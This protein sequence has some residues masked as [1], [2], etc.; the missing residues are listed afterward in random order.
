MRALL[1][2]LLGSV[3]AADG[4]ASDQRPNALLKMAQSRARFTAGRV[5]L[6]EEEWYQYNGREMRAFQHA[7]SIFGV[8]G[9]IYVL[10]GDDQGVLVRDSEGKPPPAGGEWTNPVHFLLQGGRL[11]QHE[12]QL[13]YGELF[14]PNSPN[15]RVPD[16][17]TYGI[18][19]GMMYGNLEECLYGKRPVP[20]T[21]RESREGA[22]WIVQ[23]N[24]PERVRTWWIDPQRGWNPVRVRVELTSGGWREARMVLKQFG[25]TWFP[26]KIDHFSSDWKDGAVPKRTIRVYEAE[27]NAPGQPTELTPADIGITEGMSIWLKDTF[28]QKSELGRYQ[29]GQFVPTTRYYLEQLQRGAGDIQVI[30]PEANQSIGQLRRL[31]VLLSDWERYVY[32]FIQRYTLDDAQRERALSV[33][34][35][36][37]TLARKYLARRDEEL[38]E[39]A[40]DLEGLTVAARDVTVKDGKRIEVAPD[41]QR[42][43]RAQ[44][45][46][47]RLRDFMKPLDEIFENRLKP[48]LEKLPT[49]KQREAAAKD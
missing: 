13:S 1:C 40:A 20:C 37:Q 28:L 11:W 34:H 15:T 19:A 8:S 38:A 10:R 3:L 29:N 30:A 47:E 9:R 32:E 39:I 35:E 24:E 7:T 23:A 4:T 46:D 16:V 21:Y 43:E 45:V 42:A 27:F 48:R 18:A 49:K 17:R 5:I 33:L 36:C 14:D 12:E 6:S 22:L 41:P 31:D 26:E 25:D 44:R 2:L